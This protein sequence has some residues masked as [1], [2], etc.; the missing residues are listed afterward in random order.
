MYSY[1]YDTFFGEIN[2]YY[3]NRDNDNKFNFKKEFI[4]NNKIMERVTAINLNKESNYFQ[5][6]LKDGLIII[7]ELTLT[8]KTKRIYALKEIS[9]L[10]KFSGQIN[11]IRVDEKKI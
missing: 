11:G 3:F 8:Q 6:G 10:S 9:R 2:G 1:S 4:I 7:N 5:I